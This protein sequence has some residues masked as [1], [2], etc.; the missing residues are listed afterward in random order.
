MFKRLFDQTMGGYYLYRALGAVIP[1]IP[2]ALGYPLFGAI[3]ALFFYLF[4]E[5]REPLRANLAHVMPQ[6]T[7]AEIDATARGTLRNHLKNYYDFF[8]ASR[9]SLEDI[10][11]IVTIHGLEN[12]ARALEKGKGVIF[13][14]A[15]FGNLDIVG[16]GFALHSFKVTT[17]AEHIKPEILFQEIIRVRGSKGMKIVP[18]DGPLIGLV[19]ALKRNEIVGLA[20]DLDLTKTGMCVQFFDAPARMPSGYAQLSLKTGSPIL[21]AFG[22][23]RADNTFDAF[24][25]PALE[26]ERTGDEEAD[27]RAGVERVARI[28]EKWI[29]AHP[30]QW[31]MWHRIWENDGQSGHSHTQ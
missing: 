16:Q 5:A 14:S 29:G 18:V 27:V 11:G 4:A 10:R 21:P 12:L 28:M 19:K 3:G 6:A 25:E 30:D 24:A 8:R 15:H 22:V 1:L 17:P 13:I 7:L 23:R 26:L 2:P 20:A 9:L 31:V